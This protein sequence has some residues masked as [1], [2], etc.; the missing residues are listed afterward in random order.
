MLKLIYADMKRLG[1]TKNRF[2]HI[3]STYLFDPGFKSV[4][5]YR[6]QQKLTSKF[7][8]VSLFLS[9][10]NLRIT[11]AQFCVGVEIGSGLVVR[12]P[13]GIVLGG[14]VIIGDNCTIA[15]GVTVGQNSIGNVASGE[16]PILESDINLGANSVVIGKIR[17]GC[18]VTVGAMTLV[19]KDVRGDS[20]V[21]GIPFRYAV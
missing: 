20:T 17:I 11:G 15:Q 4:V 12:H 10:F 3:L 13:S 1:P 6:V 19:N 7:P 14:G 16:Y 18:N 8:R 21:V 2:R 9:S 5:I